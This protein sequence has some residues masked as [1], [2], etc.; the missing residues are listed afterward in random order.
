MATGV[1]IW[2]R[3]IGYSQVFPNNCASF[4]HKHMR[5]MND[6]TCTVHYILSFDYFS[7]YKKAFIKVERTR[8]QKMDMPWET[9]KLS[10]LGN[11]QELYLEI[12]VEGVWHYNRY[13]K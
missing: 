4:Q 2:L 6:G 9:V 10:S 8:E 5:Y 7:R 3:W 13:I 11:K 12:L 1:Q